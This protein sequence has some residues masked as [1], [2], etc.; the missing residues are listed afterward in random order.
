MGALN[1]SL[2]YT[3]FYVEGSLPSNFRK[4]FLDAVRLYAFEPLKPE[5]DDEERHGW[6]NIE[7]PLDLEF[8]EHK[9]FFNEYM[10]LALRIDKWRIP[11]PILKA[12]CTEAE[13]D[14]LAKN[15][16]EKLRKSEKEDIKALVTADMKRRL[17]P[18]LKTI[19]MSWN[20]HTGMVRFWN[21]SAKTCE[22]FQDLFEQ[23]FNLRLVPD[24]PYI[25]ALQGEMNGDQ[26]SLLPQLEPT[27]FHRV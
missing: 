6:C 12:Y 2:S 14:Y 11:G 10:N 4:V 18:T 16:K 15:N 27:T 25:S 5:D 7:H 23:T 22:L 24:S 17:F 8:D 26:M 20:V 3:R 19:D 9:I 1:G 21:Q 13:R